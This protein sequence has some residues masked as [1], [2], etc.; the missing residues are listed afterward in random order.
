MTEPL[1]PVNL[2]LRVLTQ[3]GFRY[4]GPVLFSNSDMIQ[5]RD[6]RSG[7]IVDI[8]LHRIELI[9]H[10]PDPEEAQP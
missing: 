5:L 3:Q 9:E 8:S 10:V 1:Y 7:R 6:R 2:E 4:Q